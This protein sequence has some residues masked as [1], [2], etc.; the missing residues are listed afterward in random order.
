VAPD[1]RRPRQLD[2]VEAERFTVRLRRAGAVRRALADHRLA[3]DQRRPA[4]RALRRGDGGI[5]GVDVVAVDTG[6]DI[7]AIGFEALR[8]VVDEPRRDIAVDG[9]AVV[10]VENDE[11][12]QL[13]DRRK[14]AGLVADAFHQAA[15]AGEGVG[16]VVD[17]GVAVAVELAGEQLLGERH[18]DRIGEALAERAGGGLDRRGDAVFRVARRLAV[19]LAEVAE[20]GKREVVAVRCST[21]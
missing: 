13:P 3:D 1:Q 11:L 20:L 14:R 17:D 9:D 4:G 7:P 21:A 5:D 18:A 6:D 12:V 19:E 15:V 10:V 2:L 8:R 16:V